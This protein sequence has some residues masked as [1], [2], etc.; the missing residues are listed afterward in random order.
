[1]FD[2]IDAAND[3][4]QEGEQCVLCTVVRLVGSGYGRPGARL[5]L[6]QS[7]ERFGYISGG[8]LERELCLRAWQITALGPRLVAFDT[9]QD[10]GL[11]RR[12]NAGCEG[13][14]Y[15]LCARLHS[16]DDIALKVL[17]EAKDGRRRLSLL[18]VYR[19]DSTMT[20]A[21][22]MAVLKGEG[23]L[24]GPARGFVESCTP[25]LELMRSTTDR[26]SLRWTDQQGDRVEAAIEVLRPRPELVI[27][28]AGD[29]AIAVH[30]AAAAIGWQVTI[31]DKRPDRASVARFPGTNVRSG[32]WS[33][34]ARE[35]EL[36]ADTQVLL[37]THDFEADVSLVHS[38][39]DS[40]VGSI[41]VMG[42]KRRLA[43]VIASVYQRGRCIAPHEANRLR[44]PIGL[45]IGAVT[46]PEIAAS[47]VAE[48]LALERRR[49]GGVLNQRTEQLH[50]DVPHVVLTD[51]SGA[52]DRF[53]EP[54]EPL[55]AALPGKLL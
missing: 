7:G 44:S 55:A 39:V 36:Q 23:T 16:V 32:A 53:G 24:D 33:K 30:R 29:D 5:L 2:I 43:K 25:V 28:G 9:R 4:L 21:G 14:L 45:D 46:P 13:V 31:A 49:N 52:S 6:T 27:F 20:R 42:S 12:H 15:V 1:M 47:I 19:S 10:A 18:T 41:G 51:E 22:D 37:M 50:D 35:L 8:C 54:V 38:L 40:P 17:Q 26:L 11:E 3:C 34:I 48:L